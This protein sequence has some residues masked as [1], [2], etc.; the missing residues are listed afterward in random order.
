MEEDAIINTCQDGEQCMV[1]NFETGAYGIEKCDWAKYQKG[2]L[3]KPKFPIP[4]YEQSSIP[5]VPA[6]SWLTH[7]DADIHPLNVNQPE[8]DPETEAALEAAEN[9]SMMAK[10]MN[11][12]VNI[13]VII[14][15]L[16]GVKAIYSFITK[17]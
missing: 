10:M 12:I 2:P 14:L 1:G 15:I 16:Y 17:E 7:Y 4:Y 3:I 6:K 8:I 5:N 9:N 13:F 11:L